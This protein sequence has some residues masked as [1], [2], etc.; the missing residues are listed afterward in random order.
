MCIRS[1][2]IPMNI[3]V[4]PLDN[5]FVDAF[6][7]RYRTLHGNRTF[8]KQ[9]FARGLSDLNETWRSGGHSDGHQYDAAAGGFC[10][11]LWRACVHGHRE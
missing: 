8:G 5:P 4:R 10:G 7:D 3:V 9:D 1:T 2:A 6:V 11:F